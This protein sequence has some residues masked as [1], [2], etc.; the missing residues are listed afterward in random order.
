[1][2]SSASHQQQLS[3]FESRTSD[4]A[5]IAGDIAGLITQNMKT[6]MAWKLLPGLA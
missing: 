4:I 2:R 6:N 3:N 5:M 1:M